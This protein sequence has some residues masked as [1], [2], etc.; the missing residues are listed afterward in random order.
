MPDVPTTTTTV[1]E[2]VYTEWISPAMQAH[3]MEYDSPTFLAWDIGAPANNAN[4]IRIPRP[5]SDAG[6]VGDGGGGVDIEYDM[7]EATALEAIAFETTEGSL[8]LGKYGI[9][10][11]V[12]AETVEDA[13]NGDQLINVMLAHDAEIL[14]TAFNDDMC[15]N[16]ASASNASGTTN[17]TLGLADLDDAIDD[18]V[19]RGANGAIA[20]VLDQIQRRHTIAAFK[21]AGSNQAIYQGTADRVMNVST[22]ESPDFGNNRGWFTRYR[23]ADFYFTGLTDSANSDV[24]VVGCAFIRGD[25]VSNQ[26]WASFTTS[27][28]RL[29]R[30]KVQEV[31]EDDTVKMVTT[32]RAG[33]SLSYN[34]TAQKIVTKGS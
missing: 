1:E 32:M 13:I 20:V 30:L 4:T 31:V 27:R 29:P 18:I 16:F 6:T 28:K 11:K 22:A 7:T 17:T 10:R 12:S 9:Y 25:V 23:E 34:A 5:V 3:L 19:D 2:V 26:K 14:Q 15:G 21:A 24:D 8:T 33:V